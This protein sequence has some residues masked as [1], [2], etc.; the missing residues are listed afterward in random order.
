MT[1]IETGEADSVLLA[2]TQDPPPVLGPEVIF[3]FVAPVGTDL[4]KLGRVMKIAL[5]QVKYTSMEI[6]LSE[7]L[8]QLDR[9]SPLRN[10][11]RDARYKDFMDAGDEL[12]R[13]TNQLDA[14]AVLAV[15]DI[16]EKRNAKKAETPPQHRIAYLLRS[17]KTPDEVETLRH[18]YSG[19]FF[20][21]AAYSS[22]EKR[23]DKLIA[24]IALSYQTRRT[25]VHGGMAD[26]IV[27]RD[28]N[29][30][31]DRFGQNVRDTFPLADFFVDLDAPEEI[32]Q[33]A[34]NRFIQLVFGF[35]FHT[36]SRD[37]SG[38]YHARSA[39]L[40]SAELGRQVGAAITTSAA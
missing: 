2:S 33:N 18:I 7:L 37:E 35:E 21:I 19:G 15:R 23:R 24:D 12:R 27:A 3:G 13:K 22:L 8:Q 38:M 29:D 14:L 40:R 17:L 5:H 34:V 11:P 25:D 39:A 1:A 30:S 9:K 28:E 4:D 31:N 6:R 32:L 10:E 20:L 16:R 26:E 36:P